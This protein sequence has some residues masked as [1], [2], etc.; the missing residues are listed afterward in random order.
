MILTLHYFLVV[1]NP[2][3]YYLNLTPFGF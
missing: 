2:R 1:W 3:R